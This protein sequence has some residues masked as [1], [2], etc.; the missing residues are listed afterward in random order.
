MAQKRKK[1]LGDRNMS[2]GTKVVIGVFAVI[3]AL[4]MTL[5]SLTQIFAGSAASTQDSAQSTEADSSSSSADASSSASTTQEEAKTDANDPT[6]KVPE[7]ET[8]KS[9]AEQNKKEVEKY[10]KRLDQ[11][12]DNMAATLHLGQTYMN[13]GYSAISSSSTDEEKEYSK[14]L[15][16]KAIGYYDTYLKNNPDSQAALVQRTLCDYYMGNT[17]QSINKLK[18]MTQKNPDLALAW[19]YLGILSEQS[20]DMTT[21]LDAYQKAVETDPNDEYGVKSYAEQRVKSINES[22]G[23]FDKLTNKELLSSD[24]QPSEGLPGIIANKSEQ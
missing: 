19:A 11:N 5:P 4:S 16:N 2:T 14:A 22:Q 7:N 12:P 24:S 1:E 21:A 9:L 8:L 18:E 13:W 15:I 3:M 23:N 10:Q 6:A 20:Y 17:E